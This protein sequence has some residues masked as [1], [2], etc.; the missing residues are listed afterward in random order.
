MSKKDIAVI[1]WVALIVGF[2][3]YSLLQSSRVLW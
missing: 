1:I 3:V 2:T